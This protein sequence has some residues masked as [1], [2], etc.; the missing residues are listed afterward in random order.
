MQIYF[1]GDNWLAA[2]LGKQKIDHTPLDNAFVID[3]ARK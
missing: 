3:P 1:N 2:L